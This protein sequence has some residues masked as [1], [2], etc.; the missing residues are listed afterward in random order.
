MERERDEG[1][2]KGNMKKNLFPA[3]AKE[4]KNSKIHKQ[5]QLLFDNQPAMGYHRE[6]QAKKR[7]EKEKYEQMR[8]P[9]YYCCCCC[10]CYS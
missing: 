2:N 1:W 4:I 5:G 3:I 9:V 7:K 10:C 6:R 8:E